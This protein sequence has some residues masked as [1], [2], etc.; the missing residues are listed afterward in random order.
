[1]KDRKVVIV[2]EYQRFFGDVFK[3]TMKPLAIQFIYFLNRIL[4]LL[5]DFYITK[6]RWFRVILVKVLF[7]L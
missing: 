5:N 2:V 1:M 7:N 6:K 4:Y 3:N